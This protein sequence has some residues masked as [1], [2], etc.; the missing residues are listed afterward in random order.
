MTS[1]WHLRRAAALLRQGGI[2]AYP[3]EAVFGLGCDPWNEIALDRLIGLKG[4]SEAKGLILVAADPAQ[5]EPF[6]LPLEKAVRERLA[7]TWP[8]PVTW[9]VHSRPGLPAALTGGRATVAVRVTRHPVAAA[10]C[11][12]FGGALVS[13]SANR[14]GRSPARSPFQV[15]RVFGP[16]LDYI[17]HGA[18]GGRRRPSEIREASSG[19][20]LRPG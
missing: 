11:R 15:R 1:P 13:T 3:T 9:I 2:V 6:V 20:I 18:L 12:E 5:L 14:A 10:L 4:R 17:L 16:R 7:A 19:R 8:G